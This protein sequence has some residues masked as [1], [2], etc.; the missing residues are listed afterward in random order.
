V[1][2]QIENRTEAGE[3]R[4]WIISSSTMMLAAEQLIE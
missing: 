4:V 2:W 3:L 1:Q